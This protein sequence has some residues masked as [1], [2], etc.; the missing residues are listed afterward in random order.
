[1]LNLRKL[2]TIA[3]KDIYIRFTDRNLFLIMIATPL[4]LSTVIGLA[5]GELGD[6]PA[7]IRDIPVAIVNHDQGNSSGVNY[8]QSFVLALITDPK[9]ET[10]QIPAQDCGLGGA[11]VGT[12]RLMLSDLT[13]AVAFDLQLAQSI[14]ESGEISISGIN[15]D[16]EG[17]LEAVAR[18]AVDVG[19]YRVAI[20]IP[21]DFTQKITY[22][23]LSHPTIEGTNV[24]VYANSGSPISGGIVRAIVEGISNQL[25][26]GN[27]AVAATFS[28][29]EQILG[30]G[31][32]GQAAGMLD[33][34]TAFACGF[35]PSS[36][37]IFL[38]SQTVTTSE[39]RNFASIILVSAGSAQAM[40]F[41][42]F[43]AQAGVFSMHD[44]RRGWTLQRLFI[45]PTQRSIIMAGKLVGVFISVLVQLVLLLIALTLVASLMQGEMVFIWG[46]HILSIVLVLLSASLAVSG[47]GMLLAG[48][49][50]S[51]EQAQ[52]IGSVVNIGLAVLGGAFGFNLPEN[53]SQ[54]SLVYWGR[55]A[56]DMLAAGQSDIDLNVLVLAAQGIGMFALGL[57]LFNRYFEIQ[58]G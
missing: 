9:N 30:L 54:F 8:G 41:A 10:A 57:V 53:I 33:F 32:I 51:A 15:P 43:T 24:T 29:M 22:T 35:S 39:V 6:D 48:V 1:M 13:E 2:W 37:S 14:A 3:W 20:I 38:D 5:F 23:P 16:D 46:T 34:N 21:K 44:E 18:A 42:L 47:L 25:L 31:A 50:K 28:G 40:F 58:E 26:T 52:T 19:L 45:S 27:I 17:Y 7:P 56:F 55:N 4:A 36:N 11:A 49:L 12:G